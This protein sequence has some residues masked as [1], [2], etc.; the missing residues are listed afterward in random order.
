MQYLISWLLDRRRI[1]IV[2]GFAAVALTAAAFG[3]VVLKW[4]H[5]RQE[6]FNLQ[7]KLAQE[8]TL[9]NGAIAMV[10]QGHLERDSLL[11]LVEAAK[12]SG[13]KVVAGVKVVVK[14]RVVTVHDTVLATGPDTAR[15]AHFADSNEV[16][17]IEGDVTATPTEFY[18]DYHFTRR[19]IV[20]DVGFVQVGDSTWVVAKAVGDS[21]RVVAPYYRKPVRQSWVEKYIGMQYSQEVTARAGAFALILGA[22]A[23]VGRFQLEANLTQPVVPIHGPTATIGL[24]K[25]F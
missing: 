23:R 20:I 24:T 4:K 18:F 1:K 22:D 2:A 21:V 13:G 10:A 14:E 3:F 16:A 7:A 8:I 17:T 11:T 15:T 19:P 6:R 12:E 5:E 9:K 25:T